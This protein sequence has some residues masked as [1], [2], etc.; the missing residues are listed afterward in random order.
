[1]HK[2]PIRLRL[3]IDLGDAERPILLGQAADLSPL[4]LDPMAITTIF[5]EA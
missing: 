1:M 5:S 2:L 3:S 4:T